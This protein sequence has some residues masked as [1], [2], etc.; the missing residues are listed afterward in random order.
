MSSASRDS[1]DVAPPPPAPPKQWQVST[2]TGPAAGT[3]TTPVLSAPTQPTPPVIRPAPVPA[4]KP[5][6]PPPRPEPARAAAPPRPAAAP[7]RPQPAAAPKAPA[8]RSGSVNGATHAPPAAPPPLL[9]E[10]PPEPTRDSVDEEDTEN[11]LQLPQSIPSLV[12]RI[13]I[14]KQPARR[15]WLF[16]LAGLA[17]VLLGVGL[18]LFFYL[19]SGGPP[20]AP[21]NPVA[22]APVH[23]P[24]GKSTLTRAMRQARAGDRFVLDGDIEDCNVGV[25][26]PGI[27]IEAAPGKT[28]TWRCPPDAAAGTKLLR[29]E[30]VAN[31]HV[32]GITLDGSGATEAVILLFGKTPGT[33]LSQVVVSN[34]KQDGVVFANCSGEEGHPVLLA[35]VT[36]HTRDRSQSAVRF[37]ILDNLRKQ[38]GDQNRF[39]TVDDKCKFLGDG[40]KVSAANPDFVDPQTVKLPRGVSLERV[41]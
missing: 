41:P 1:D 11:Q 20:P 6:S 10:L 40:H 32:K 22:R 19:S 4:S 30:G 35:D 36:F 28:I 38:N 7:P 39:V 9:D 24:P 17:A 12:R 34:T 18:V 5:A 26:A 14:Q 23:V 2:N 31:V 21:K 13:K 37:L 3:A 33:T 8:A 25:N 15:R 27:T 29:I 16:W